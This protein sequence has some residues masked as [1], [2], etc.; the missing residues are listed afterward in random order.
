MQQ[1]LTTIPIIDKI[2]LELIKMN[3]VKRLSKEI[4]EINDLSLKELLDQL[5]N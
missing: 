2:F 1:A 5:L 3:C 4:V